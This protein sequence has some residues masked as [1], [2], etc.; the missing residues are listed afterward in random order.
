MIDT[1]AIAITLLCIFP[2]TPLPQQ[3]E[4]SDKNANEFARAILQNEL[5]AEA[6]DHSHWMLMLEAEK[7]GEKEVD[8]V[9]ETKDG[10]LKRPLLINGRPL[11]AKQEQEVDEQIRRMIGDAKALHKSLKQQNEDADRSQ[12]LLKMLPDALIFSFGERRGDAVRL[13]F[14]PNYNFRPANR[15][16]RVFQAMEGDLWVDS[17]QGRLMEISGHLT[18]EVKFGGGLLGYLNAGGTFEVKQAE[19]ARGFWELTVLNVNMKGKALFFRTIGVQQRVQRSDFHRIQDN[20]T[21]AE[22]ADLLRKQ[23][24]AGSRSALSSQN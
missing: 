9:I 18:R 10:E 15:E 4:H 3:S 7:S 8:Q 19:V 22:A 6:N 17:K 20:L 14:T 12:R 13:H 1:T 23:I 16:A 11:T 2:A 21:L 5:N 24:I